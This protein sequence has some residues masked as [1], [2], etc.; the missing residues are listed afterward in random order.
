MMVLVIGII[1]IPAQAQEPQ[2]TPEPTPGLLERIFIPI[3]GGWTKIEIRERT[4]VF[5]LRDGSDTGKEVWM[6]PETGVVY[7]NRERV[8]R[9]DVNQRELVVWPY[10]G[11][12]PG[13]PEVGIIFQIPDYIRVSVVYNECKWHPYIVPPGSGWWECNWKYFTAM[14]WG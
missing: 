5:W 9:V 3:V 11:E 10:R 1:P 7:P 14:P 4:V 8:E 13:E 2:Q 12:S 6:D